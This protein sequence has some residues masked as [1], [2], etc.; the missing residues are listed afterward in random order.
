MK[1]ANNHIDE[2]D[3]EKWRNKA[4]ETIN[5]KIAAKKSGCADRTVTNTPERQWN[6]CDDNQR[7][8]DDRRKNGGL[9][10]GKAH[11]VEDAELGKSDGEHRWNDGE[12][13]RDVVGDR[14][15][16]ERAASD[17]ELFANFDDLNEFGGIRIEI[18]H[19][20]G[21]LGGLRAG[22]H[23]DANI[24]LREGGRVVGAVAGHGDEAAFG[25]FAFDEGHLV[26]GLCFGEKIVD[27]GLT[28]NSSGSQRIV[29]GD[30]HGAN[31]HSTE[32]IEAFAHAAFDDVRK[33]D[34][35]E[36]AAILRDE[37]RRATRAGDFLGY[38]LD[39]VRND[40][41]A[42]VNVACNGLL[43]ALANFA[44]VDIDTGH[45]SLRREGMEYRVMSGKITAAELVAF[46]G[47]DDD[48]AA[49]RGFVGERR[50]LCGVCEMRFINARR[51]EKVSRG[52]ITQRD[53]A[54]F[55]EEK[56]VDVACGFDGPAGHGENVAAE[57]A[58]HA[59]DA[60][61]GQQTTDGGGNQTNKERREHENILWS[62]RIDG[63]RL[64]RDDGEKEKNGETR[65]KNVEGNFVGSFLTLCAFDETDHTVEEGLARI[66]RDADFDFVGKN[67]SAAGN[68][69]AISAGFA[70]NRSGFAG[71]GGFIDGSDA[72]DDFAVAGNHFAGGHQNE[73]ACFQLRA[74]DFFFTAGC[75]EAASESFGASLAERFR[76]RF[77]AAFGH[78]FGEI[79]EK[80]GK[81]EPE[82]DLEAKAETRGAI[83]N[84]V[85]EIDRGD[86]G[87]DFD[88]EH[89]RVLIENARIE[90]E[91]RFERS[92]ANQ[93]RESGFFSGWFHGR[94]F[95]SKE[96]SG[97]HLQVLENGAEAKDRK[98]RESANDEN[99]G[100][101]KRG[102]ER[103]GHGKSAS[104][105][106]D[107]FFLSEVSRDCENWYHGEETPEK[108]SDGERTVV[109]VRIR[110]DAVEG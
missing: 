81:P 88:D 47:E 13:F 42:L 75:G 36:D 86:Y 82:R 54:S 41:A 38:S 84:T 56:N 77:A 37:K 2:L 64:K 50:K 92:A 68:G 30:H 78:G 63:E 76:L 12:V 110:V 24:C 10:R 103:R 80:N 39:F 95:A 31:A 20:A 99:R 106:R 7:V 14:E 11:D 6:Q 16:G 83:C 9:R 49:F 44:A 71:D 48:G 107:G 94:Q 53:G 34:H 89:D 97:C 1:R 91:K 26:F 25:L 28:R 100:D 105:F 109:P 3:S 52:A 51:G 98:K 59:G 45:A 104:G 102:E 93:R 85:D 5:K 61:G 15:S 101:E 73:I 96:L 27:T 17:Q 46:L 72:F 70:N 22:I 74:G 108:H 87:A 19:V 4:A 33:C 60:D 40:L 58:V 43:C 18:N 65:E 29:A 57:Q 66:C 8:E 55:V 79:G 35:T 32:M 90:L 69:R 62:G 23:G 21:F 67:A